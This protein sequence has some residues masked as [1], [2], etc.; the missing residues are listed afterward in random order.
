[1]PPKLRRLC[2]AQSR[3]GKP[4]G[5]WA[6]KGSDLCWS[7]NEHGINPP[8]DWNAPA[9]KPV[10]L[11]PQ[12]VPLKFDDAMQAEACKLAETGLSK[13]AVAKSLGISRRTLE[14]RIVAD[15]SFAE[16]WAESYDGSTEVIEDKLYELAKQGYMPAV[17]MVLE[18]RKPE[19]YRAA[20][21]PQNL[22]VHVKGDAHVS[23]SLDEQRERLRAAY[24]VVMKEPMGELPPPV[25]EGEVIE[26]A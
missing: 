10:R 26:D 23:L 16:R 21:N 22:T 9:A 7:H 20:Q 2:I 19:V 18:S 25:I 6:A 12:G 11:H 17:K 8:P 4:C 1:M 15:P 5:K 24:A 3:S 14:R 13:H